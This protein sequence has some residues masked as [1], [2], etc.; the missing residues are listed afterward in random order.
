M[1]RTRLPW[2][3]CALLAPA[4]ALA[5]GAASQELADAMRSTPNL[6]RGAEIFRTCAACHGPKGAGTVDGGVPRL[7]GQHVT[8]LEKQLVDYRHDRRWDIRME[9][10]AGK[11][12]LVDAQAIA[13]VATYANQLTVE[14][15]PGVGD[16]SDEQLAHGAHLYEE[17]CRSCHALSAQ[18]SAQKVVPRIAGQHYEYL[19]RQ[20]YDAVDGR[21]PNFSSSHV[22]LF[23]RLERAD[24]TALADYLSRIDMRNEPHE[25]AVDRISGQ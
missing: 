21:R 15:S 12:L 19:M 14:T 16:G 10:F 3:L 25:V 7:A 20:I 18:G 2:A 5:V 13:D 6:D 4:A 23:A 17:R 1:R 22:K 24:I 11:H 8:V 9:H